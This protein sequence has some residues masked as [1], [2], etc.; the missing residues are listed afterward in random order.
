MG[1]VSD[2]SNIVF[3]LSNTE[4]TEQISGD[5]GTFVRATPAT[6]TDSNGVIQIAASGVARFQDDIGYFGEKASTNKCTNY[7]ANPASGAFAPTDAIT[8]NTNTTNLNAQNGDGST[9]WGVVDD[10]T[11]LASAGLDGLCTSGLVYKIDN[12]AGAVAA[13]IYVIGGAANTNDHTITAHMRITSGTARLRLPNGTD[14][15][16]L[17]SNTSY[18]RITTDCVA[19]AA[20]DN[21]GIQANAGCVVYFILN[22][23]EE[24]GFATSEI[25]TEGSAVTRNKDDYDLSS[26]NIPA[27]IE[28]TTDF[29]PTAAGQGTIYICG[30]Y[31]DASNYTAILHDGT[32]FIARKRIAAVN[33]DATKAEAYVADTTYAIKAT[34]SSTDGVGIEIDSV[35]GTGDS[36]TADIQLGSTIEIGSLNAASQQT[37]GIKNFTITSV[38]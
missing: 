35:A 20:T 4:T 34:F 36:N 27:S 24:S 7:N 9:L 32:N 21:I 3:R 38:L 8:F 30:S 1:V 14:I 28:I 12:S 26:S 29:T 10:A 18:E 25:I 19:V 31:V 13:Y 33:Y 22:Q 23:L 37:G 15:G 6:Y 2:L 5:A 17:L 11:E 16:D